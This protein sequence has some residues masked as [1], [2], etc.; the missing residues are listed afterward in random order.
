MTST[1]TTMTSTTTPMTTTS[2][3]MTTTGDCWKQVEKCPPILNEQ[4][5]IFSYKQYKGLKQSLQG[6]YAV[7]KWKNGKC[8]TKRKAWSPTEPTPCTTTTTPTTMTTTTTT[9]T[10]MT[11][12]STT[13]TTTGDCWKQVQKCPPIL[14]EQECIFSYKQYKGLMQSLQRQYAVCKWKNGKCK[15]KQKTWSPTEPTPCTTTT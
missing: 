5:C 14:N 3:T 13:M 6:Q 12:T 7:C 8:K 2:T 10:P 1:S 11:T 15:T 4:E 9:T